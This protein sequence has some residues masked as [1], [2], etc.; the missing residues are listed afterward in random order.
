MDSGHTR[1][2]SVLTRSQYVLDHHSMWIKNYTALSS[3]KPTGNVKK[4]GCVEEKEKE[5]LQ[6]HL[7][8][9]DSKESYFDDEKCQ[10]FHSY[11][12]FKT[13]TSTSILFL[14]DHRLIID[15]YIRTNQIYISFPPTLSLSS[16]GIRSSFSFVCLI[17]IS[18]T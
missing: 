8:Q 14:I 3:R 13:T 2:I 10:T 6:I 17:V 18:F 9:I 5:I 16:D 1:S 7:N 15:M 11:P 12:L 4:I